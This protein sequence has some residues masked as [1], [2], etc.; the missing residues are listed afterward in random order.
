MPRVFYGWWVAAACFCTFGIIVGIPY[1]SLPFFF[2]YFE[3][4]RLGF[5]WSRPAIMLGSP[6]GV[7]VTVW[8]GP[9]LVQRFRPRKLLL[10]GTVATAAALA[11]FAAMRGQIWLYYLLWCLYMVGYISAGPIPHQVLIARWFRKLRGRAMGA[12]YVG[13][14]LCGAVSAKY[15]ARPLTEAFGFRTALTV[16]GLL[17]F[18]TWPLI[19]WVMRDSPPDLGLSPDGGSVGAKEELDASFQFGSLLRQRAFWLLAIASF[20]SIA[21]IGAVNQHMKLILKDQGFAPQAAL[22]RAFSDTLFAIMIT[23][24]AGR[25]VIGWLADHLSKKRLMTAVYV[26]VA[27]SIP[28][29][30]AARPPGTPYLF[31]VLFGLS[32]GGD[33]LLIPLMAAEQFGVDALGRVMAVIMPLDLIG[34]TWLPYLVSILQ[35]RFGDYRIAAGMLFPIALAGAIL[36]ALLPATKLRGETNGI[37]DGR[38]VTQDLV[39]L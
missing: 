15:V 29:L 25:V 11:G 18:L 19:L 20:C 9:L 37:K 31:A 5:G 14:G 12:T 10:F 1:Y 26:I 3:D 6:L 21:S 7:L 34:L 32:M 17:L 35:Q 22:N 13:V 36:V 38:P 30:L 23:S 39:K 16:I 4:A 2:D 24:I 8:A 27:G 33:Y 28:L